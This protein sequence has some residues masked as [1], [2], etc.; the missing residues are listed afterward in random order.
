MSQEDFHVGDKVKIVSPNERYYGCA[1]TVYG[2]FGFHTY[3]IIEDGTEHGAKVPFLHGKGLQKVNEEEES[4]TGKYQ[5][6]LIELMQVKQSILGP[7]V[8]YFTFEDAQAL[9]RLSDE[10]AKDIYNIIYDGKVQFLGH[11]TCPFCILQDITE[12][13]SESCNGCKYKKNHFHCDNKDSDFKKAKDIQVKY[14]LFYS[15]EY[16]VE[17]A[18]EQA[19]LKETGPTGL[20]HIDDMSE[21]DVAEQP[22]IYL[23]NNGS[24]TYYEICIEADHRVSVVGSITVMNID[25]NKAKL[26]LCDSKVMFSD[27]E[28]NLT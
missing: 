12:G 11:S 23:N 22:Y 9:S 25:K 5:K 18:K 26:R 13:E 8:N 7:E 20:K 28:I 3:V 6:F 27:T 21:E 10:R 2:N 14:N 19:G 15:A 4:M 17:L 1:G 16:V 24:G